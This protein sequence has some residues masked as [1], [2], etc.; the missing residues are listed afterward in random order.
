LE[1]QK[2]ASARP[3]SRTSPSQWGFVRPKFKCLRPVY[4]PHSVRR[5]SAW[6]VISLG[7]LPGTQR[8]EQSLIP[9]R[10]CSRRGLPGRPHYCGRRWSL[11]PPFHHHPPEGRQLFSVARSGR[12]LRPG[13]S[14]APRSMECGL[15]STTH[16]SAPPRP[17]DRPEALSSYLPRARASIS[18]QP[19][20]FTTEFTES[21]EISPLFSQ[22]TLCSLWREIFNC[23]LATH[24]L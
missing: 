7:G 8:D 3:V 20:H 19:P 17:S 21:T 11:T 22:R 1:I 5:R 16:R 10:P 24:P 12:L 9:V 15:S 6:T 18:R 23:S 13:V 4:K 14:P 2:S